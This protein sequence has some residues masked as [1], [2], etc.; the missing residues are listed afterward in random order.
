[1]MLPFVVG[2][3]AETVK[4]TE[5]VG[6]FFIMFVIALLLSLGLTFPLALIAPAL[7]IVAPWETVIL[8]NMAGT[9]FG[10]ITVKI[11]RPIGKFITRTE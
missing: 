5:T 2:V 4:E 6:E 3:V 10:M 11:F 7:A 9:F 8:T 1:M